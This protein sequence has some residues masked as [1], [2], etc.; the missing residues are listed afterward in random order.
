MTSQQK[1]GPFLQKMWFKNF[2]VSKCV[3][4]KSCFLNPILI[5]ENHFQKNHDH[6]DQSKKQLETPYLAVFVNSSF[7][8]F[9]FKSLKP[10]HF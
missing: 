10:G 6:S 4:T 9:F 2:K 7:I 3:N 1:L 5:K 8:Y